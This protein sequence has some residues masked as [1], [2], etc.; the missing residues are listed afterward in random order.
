LATGFGIEPPPSGFF[1]KAKN[2]TRRLSEKSI[3]IGAAV[4]KQRWAKTGDDPI[5]AAAAFNA[6][7]LYN[8][9]AN[10]W[11]L[12]TTGDPLDRAARWYGDAC[13][14]LKEVGG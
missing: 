10:P 12:R 3:P 7:G 9:N 4:I 13:A 11:H 1:D 8:T 6:G 5:L 2:L 14:V